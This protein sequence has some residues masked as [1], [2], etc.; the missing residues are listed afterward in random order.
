M[1]QADR[2]RN[3]TLS[4]IIA[5]YRGQIIRFDKI[6]MGNKTEHNTI[7][8]PTLMQATRRRLLELQEKKWN[9]HGR[10]NGVG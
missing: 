4:D 9:L 2:R 1:N 6:G 5:F 3:T 7:I 8:T 10:S